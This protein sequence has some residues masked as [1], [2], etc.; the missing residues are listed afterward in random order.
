MLARTESTAHIGSWEWHVATDTVT[1]SDEL[2]RILHWNP[3]DGPPSWARQTGIYLPEAMAR[4]RQAVDAAVSKGMPYEL[5]LQARRPSGEV[6]ICLARGIPETGAD[7]K[8]QR[9]FGSLQDITE[10][11]QAERALRDSEEKFHALFASLTEGV[12]LHELVLD[13]GG[14]VVDYRILEVNPAFEAHTGIQATSALGRLG[15]EIYGT[16]TPPYLEEYSR[17]ALGGE[18]YAFEAYFPPLEKHFRISAVSPKPGQFATVFEDI[19]QRKKVEQALAASEARSRS[20]LQTALNGV[21]LL[22]A[23]G[24]ILEG[25]ET[26]CRMYGYAREELLGLGISGLEAQESSSNIQTRIDRI[27]SH[28]SDLFE[29]MHRRKDGTRF[30]VEVSVTLL[31]GQGQM[32]SFVRDITERRQAAEENARLQAQLQ[33]TQKMESLG[34]LAGGVAHDMNNAL[35]AILGLATA[36]LEIQPPGSPAYRSFETIAKAATRGG[37]MVR[38]LLSFARQSRAEDREVDLNAVLR[39]EAVLLERTILSKVRLELDLEAGLRPIRGD[40]NALTHAF[41]NLCV[42]ALDAMPEQGTLTLRTRNL[43]SC[44][45]EVRVEDTGTGMPQEVLAR[46]LDPF[47]T[48]KEVGK[49]TGLGLAMVYTTMKAHQGQLELHSEPGRGTQVRLRFPSCEL[50]PQVEEQDEEARSGIISRSLTVLLVDDDDLIQTS[51]QTLLQ[52]LGHAVFTA[53]SGEEALLAVDGG[54]E[55]DAVILDMNMPGLGGSGTLP[56]LRVLLPEVPVLLS[57]GR[58]DQAALELA[59][60][61]SRVTLLPKPFSLKELQQHLES[62]GRQD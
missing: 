53:A 15:T 17:V 7:G 58:T 6:R 44:W 18:P 26:A 29:S 32:V 49:G 3:A 1:W 25:N 41:M 56:R 13:G 23:E 55:P 11:K 47:F 27:R 45:V 28:G 61:H 5:E 12:A 8:V 14:A 20:M 31:P 22:D 51:I 57:T 43:D 34:T 62:L 50:A 46:A 54:L 33:Q 16:T 21:L 35:G 39:E 30:P 59:A 36:N 52:A 24:R 60:A 10:L 19:T 2:F 42:N 37:E 4:L 48:T 38:S 9:L 40:A